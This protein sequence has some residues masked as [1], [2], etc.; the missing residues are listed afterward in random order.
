[1][2]ALQFT[3]PSPPSPASP[4][5]SNSRVTVIALLPSPDHQQLLH[6]LLLLL[7]FLAARPSH[8]SSADISYADLCG[9]IVSPSTPS[10]VLDDSAGSFRLS[11]GYFVG[12]DPFLRQ[13]SSIDFSIPRSFTFFSRS[14]LHTQNPVPSRSSEP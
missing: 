3:S 14:V 9:S 12:G 8:S 6:L 5:I 1:M 2:A 10:A 7:L 13:D 4:P 11:S